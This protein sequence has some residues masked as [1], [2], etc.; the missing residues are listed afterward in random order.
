M[1]K[2]QKLS[3][4]EFEYRCNAKRNFASN[5]PHSLFLYIKLGNTI[6]HWNSISTFGTTNKELAHILKVMSGRIS[7][8]KD[9]LAGFS[10]ENSYFWFIMS[11]ESV[12]NRS[13]IKFCVDRYN[14]ERQPRFSTECL[15]G[16]LRKS[17]ISYGFPVQILNF[18]STI[19]LE[20]VTNR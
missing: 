6:T 3:F 13:S 8:K 17:Y 2:P 9:I 15:Q 12:T 10:L 4:A 14:L 5:S 16:F 1:S 20:S 19:P 7:V 18:W 11:L